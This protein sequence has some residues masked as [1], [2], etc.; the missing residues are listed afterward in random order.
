MGWSR[1][2]LSASATAALVAGLGPAAAAS[3]RQTGAGSRAPG[4]E[5]WVGCRS[6]ADAVDVRAERMSCS[7]A[8]SAIETYETSPLGCETA[9]RCI[10][11]GIDRTG[12]II[13]DNCRRQRLSVTCL[14]YIETPAG[15]IV[16][17]KLAGN[18]IAGRFDNAVVAF[19]MRRQAHQGRGS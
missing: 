7:L 19:R 16:N 12:Q 8:S 14:V 17:P 6:G 3:A 9:R 5:H 2:L 18:V 15:R 4:H 11:S 10:Q 13:I 1:H